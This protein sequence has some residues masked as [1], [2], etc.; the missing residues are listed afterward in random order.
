M[1]FL[2]IWTENLIKPFR[3]GHTNRGKPERSRAY[4]N[5]A[6][7][8]R[9]NDLRGVQQYINIFT[10]MSRLKFTDSFQHFSSHFQ[11]Y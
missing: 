6:V 3:A 11:I 7:S 5:K 1:K 8:H 10:I 2:A 4:D 9:R